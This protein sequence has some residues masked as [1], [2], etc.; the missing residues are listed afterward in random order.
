MRHT[1]EYDVLA[2][3]GIPAFISGHTPLLAFATPSQYFSRM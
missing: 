3:A 2:C 1:I